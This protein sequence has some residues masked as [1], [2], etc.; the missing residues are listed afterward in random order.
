MK[1]KG[2][3]ALVTGGSTGIGK[4]VAELYAKE[5]AN[6]IICSSR[7]VSEGEKV[8][9]ALK[10]MGTNSMYIQAD[11]TKEDEVK[12]LF[13]KIKEEYGKLDI[14]V[15]NAGKSTN[16]KFEDINQE[17]IQ[18]DIET[19]FTSAVLCSK[20]AIELMKDEGWIINTSSIRGTD[21]SGRAGLMGYCA[22]KAALN[23]FTKNLAMQLAPKIYVNAIAP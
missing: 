2:K 18:L 5:G 10:N 4:A 6:V 20:Y 12:R 7:T 3:V 13:E 1:L 17:N 15:N 21:Y 23:S 22:G 11:L 16:T 8:A 9:Q 14:L 19:N